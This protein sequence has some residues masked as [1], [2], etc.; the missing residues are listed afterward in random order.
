MAVAIQGNALPIARRR[1]RIA[2]VVVGVGGAGRIALHGTA[3]NAVPEVRA[4]DGEAV[5]AVCG[6]SAIST[7]T[8]TPSAPSDGLPGDGSRRESRAK[9]AFYFF[10]SGSRG[11]PQGSVRG[12]FFLANVCRVCGLTQ[13]TPEAQ[14]CAWPLSSMRVAPSSPWNLTRSRF[15]MPMTVVRFMP[16]CQQRRRLV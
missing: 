10:S 2:A 16:F 7:G 6:V 11:R 1:Q 13:P 14:A 9:G 12:I 15:A 3:R 8:S 4:A 5:C